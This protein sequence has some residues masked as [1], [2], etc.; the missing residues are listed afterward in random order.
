MSCNLIYKKNSQVALAIEDVEGVTEVLVAADADILAY[1]PTFQIETVRYTRN[2]ARGTMSRLPAVVGRRT[3][4]ATFSVDLAGSGDPEVLPAWVKAL[5]CCGWQA[6][7][8]TA[9][10]DLTPDS[11]CPPSATIAILHKG[12]K[13]LIYG[14]RG[15]AK[16]DGDSQNGGP[17]K[18]SFS[19]EGVYGGTIDV[20]LF[21]GVEYDAV[22]PPSFTSLGMT[23]LGNDLSV[24]TFA[25]FSFDCGNQIQVVP[26]ANAESGVAFYIIGDRTLVGSIDPNLVEVSEMDVYGLLVDGTTGTL[27]CQIG[28]TTGNVIRFAAP[29]VQI[30]NVKTQ[31]RGDIIV[32]GL[33][34]D[35][36]TENSDDEF[37]I[38]LE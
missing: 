2:P 34:L 19:F 27:A 9:G 15:N 8:T 7:A 36:V 32:A 20:D 10:Y 31:A 4:K 29:T 17:G 12:I 23:L 3:G 26:S 21:E 22:V 24:A 33:D 30:S 14:A 1:D 18:I 5:Q 11:T 35:F 38:S 25:N 13:H 28:D 37:V 6:T 16:F